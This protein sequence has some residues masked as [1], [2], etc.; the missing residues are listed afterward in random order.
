M[1]EHEQLL[2]VFFQN[3]FRTLASRRAGRGPSE[4]VVEARSPAFRHAETAGEID[5]QRSTSLPD[6]GEPGQYSTRVRASAIDGSRTPER[7]G[8]AMLPP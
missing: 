3:L 1:L 6:V 8:A 4:G 2:E 5:G 7:G